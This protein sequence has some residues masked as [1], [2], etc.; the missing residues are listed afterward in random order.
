[1]SQKAF[2]GE[3]DLSKMEIEKERLD[4]AAED[5]VGYGE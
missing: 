5:G 3:L 1:L 4:I 2:K